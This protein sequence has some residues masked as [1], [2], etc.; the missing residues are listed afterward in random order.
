MAAEISADFRFV[1]HLV[2]VLDA[3]MAYVVVFLHGNPTS[4]YFRRN[5]IPYGDAD[6]LYDV[7]KRLH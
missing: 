4:F 2:N 7:Y 1:L 6:F 3:Q 5:I